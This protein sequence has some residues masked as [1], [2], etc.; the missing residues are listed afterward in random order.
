MKLIA[1]YNKRATILESILNLIM[2]ALDIVLLHLAV[3]LTFIEEDSLPKTW[4]NSTP[5]FRSGV[6]T[7]VHF[8]WIVDDH[9]QK[10][11]VLYL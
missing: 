5:E 10:I 9:C 2:A 1:I 7:A 8:G 4:A 11:Y 6:P 3:D